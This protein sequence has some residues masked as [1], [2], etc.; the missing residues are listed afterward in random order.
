M[1]TLRLCAQSASL[2][3]VGFLNTHPPFSGAG[4]VALPLIYRVQWETDQPFPW[5]ALAYFLGVGLHIPFAV[6]DVGSGPVAA[7][8]I[9]ALYALV[10]AA[11]SLK[12]H[13]VRGQFSESAW[14]LLPLSAPVLGFGFVAPPLSAAGWWFPATGVVGVVLLVWAGAASLRAL[15]HMSWRPLWLPLALA[16]GLN[17]AYAAR[18]PRQTILRPLSFAV[19]APPTELGASL[20]TAVALGRRLAAVFGDGARQVVLPENILGLVTPGAVEA[21]AIPRGDRVIAGGLAD[22][23]WASTPQ[24]GVWILPDR[25][26]YPA[27]QPIPVIEKGL[28]PHW[29]AMG[30]EALIAGNYYSLLV[31]FEA[32]TSLPLYHLHYRVPI[33]LVGNGWWDRTGIMPIEVALARQWARLFAAPIAISQGRSLR[34]KRDFIP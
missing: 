25:V 31:C 9:W 33:I 24:K 27:I 7:T 3:L 28:R 12:P 8:V 4:F 23:P 16:L 1:S 13:F 14:T 20:R 32:S 10:A 11:F 6:W 29:D 21:L 34:R 18:P 5:F 2:L 26:F 19:N 17:I 15:D 30:R 22:V